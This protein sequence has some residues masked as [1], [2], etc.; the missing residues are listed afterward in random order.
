MKKL[1]VFTLAL[2][3]MF[4]GANIQKTEAAT[5]TDFT[6]TIINTFS[7]YH[8][9][10]MELDLYNS[11]KT[12]TFTIPP[13]DYHVANAGGS[14]PII[15]FYDKNAVEIDTFDFDL[16]FGGRYSGEFTID[17]NLLNV[18]DSLPDTMFITIPQ[19][20]GAQPSGYFAY[21]DAYDNNISYSY[22]TGYP[23]DANLL[24]TGSY[25]RINIDDYKIPY[26]TNGITFN[27]ND[28][29]YEPISN[30][31]YNTQLVLYNDANA[32]LDTIAFKDYITYDPQLV[33]IEIPYDPFEYVLNDATKFDVFIYVNENMRH[34]EMI[35]GLKSLVVTFNDESFKTITFFSETEIYA[36]VST[37]LNTLFTYPPD[38]T[39]PTGYEFA[40][41]RTKTGEAFDRRILLFEDLEGSTF[42]LYAAFKIDA[43]TFDPTLVDPVQRTAGIF[44]AFE[45]ILAGF[46]FDTTTGYMLLYA[47]IM[48]AS[49]V[50]L[51]IKHVNPLAMSMIGLTI[52]IGFTFWGVIPILIVTIGYF[53]FALMI[54][55]SLNGGDTNEY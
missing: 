22:F 26:N 39:P 6:Y 20:F 36:N 10:R 9:L 4:T 12:V 3:T 33:V 1:I 54:G 15:S 55:Y 14:T 48:I 51:I 30:T 23:F 8:V 32:A 2:L 47:F 35:A 38:P 50:I 13:S 37:K 41:W 34:D 25:T 49:L 27:F 52:H 44:G 5:A 29:N 7:T 42:L 11:V 16:L 43:N 28:F 21:L 40:G 24:I 18:Y 31:L 46:G 17:L 45:T 53:V 19:S